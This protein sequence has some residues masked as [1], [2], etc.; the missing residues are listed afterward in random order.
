MTIKEI[1]EAL[2]EGNSLKSIAQAYSEIA[3][4]KIKKIRGEVVRNRQFFE[5][6]SFVYGL[7]KVLADK[8]KISAQKNKKT[9]SL[10]LTSN[11]RFYGNINADLIDF[12]IAT[13]SKLD[14]DILLVNK[15]AIDYFKA[16][17]SLHLG[18]IKAY[19]PGELNTV[20]LKSDMP[21]PLE[22]QNLVNIVKDYNQVLIFY[23]K[24][25]SLLIQTPQV[26]DLSSAQTQ[27]QKSNQM[28]FK[29]IFEPEL[30]KIL[31]FFDNQIITLILEEAFLESEASR[32]ASR[33]ISM[34]QAETDANKFI[35]EYTILRANAK[36]IMD[37]NKILENYATMIA[38]K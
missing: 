26:L 25:K 17:A 5:E 3:N 13:I 35:K 4:I 27:A 6:I 12:F 20:M 33:F 30:P 11:F 32:T 15:A 18:G 36:K 22:L 21:N 31:A 16:Q 2:E 28:D 34:D 8:K 37:N 10:I 19:L 38:V 23:S 29:F 1:D 14:T 24:L 9:I 7:I